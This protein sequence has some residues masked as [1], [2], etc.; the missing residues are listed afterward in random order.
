MSHY[1]HIRDETQRR[2]LAGASREFSEKLRAQPSQTAK[3]WAWRLYERELA[4][5]ILR[6]H[7]HR[8]YRDALAR[9]LDQIESHARQLEELARQQGGAS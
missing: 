6:P 3:T 8:L 7:L 5:E 9:E 1:G 2:M 4:G